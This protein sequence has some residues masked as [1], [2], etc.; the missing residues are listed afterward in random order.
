MPMGGLSRQVRACYIPYVTGYVRECGPRPC[1]ILL[2]FDP[3]P[4]CIYTYIYIC[5]YTYEVRTSSFSSRLPS[6]ALLSPER[7]TPSCQLEGNGETN[8]RRC[9]QGCCHDASSPASVD[10]LH[11][12]EF[13]WGVPRTRGSFLESLQ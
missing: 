3:T 12:A 9:R 2:F 4:I 10:R 1:Y 6:C 11:F 8:P 13:V 7:K 5:I